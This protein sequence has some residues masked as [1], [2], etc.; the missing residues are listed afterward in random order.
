[1]AERHVDW[2]DTD[3]LF[4]DVLEDAAG[5]TFLEARGFRPDRVDRVSALDPL[6]VD[7]GELHGRELRARADSYRLVALDDVSDL[8]AVYNLFVEV[9]DDMLGSDAPHTY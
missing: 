8:R 9:S 1:V 4:S 6:R 2:L 3:S 5:E 7:P